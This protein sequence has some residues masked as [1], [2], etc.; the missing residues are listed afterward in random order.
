[1]ATEEV[2]ITGM[3]FAGTTAADKVITL[4]ISN[5]GTSPVT[6]DAAVLV[7][8]AT[9]AAVY[10]PVS[11]TVA[12]NGAISAEIA[13]DWAEGSNYQV[14]LTSTKGNTFTY[15]AVAPQA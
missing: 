7:N 15:T 2:K 3:H 6:L 14:R 8:G 12:A 10:D 5:V 1:M 4:D 9:D 13:Y 11:G